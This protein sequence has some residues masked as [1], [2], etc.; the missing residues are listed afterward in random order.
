MGGSSG[1]GAKTPHVA[2]ISLESAQRLKIVDLICEG[3]KDLTHPISEKDVLLNGTPLQNA[4]D[5]YNFEGVEL[6]FLP[7]TADQDYLPGFESS[8][9]VVSVG[10]EIKHS[11]SVTRQ[12]IDPNISR[13]RITIGFNALEEIREN[14]DTEATS[15][16]IEVQLHNV[17]RNLK[18]SQRV[19][20]SGRT[21]STYHRDIEFS[22]LPPTPFNMTVIRHTEDS[23]SSS[24]RNKSFLT[25]YVESIDAK[26]NYPHSVVVGI[27]ID[28]NLFG[29]NV[30]T[31]TYRSHWTVVEVPSNYNPETREYNGIWNGTFKRAWT[32]NP[33]WIY[34]DLVLND[35]YGLARYRTDI[36]VD[37][38]ALYSIAQYCDELVDDGNGGQEPRFTCNCYITSPRDAYDV[39]SDLAS[40][41][42]GIAFYDGLQYVA[43]QDR[44][45][46]PVAVYGNS[47]VVDGRF[48]YSGVSYKDITTACIVKFADKANSFI[49]DS[50]Q[51]QDDNAIARFG[52][53]VKQ[54]TA[55]GC[56]SRGQAQRVA[57]WMVETAIRERESVSFEV[58]REGIKHLPYDIIRIADNDY[59]GAQLSARVLAVDGEV[60]ALD[61]QADAKTRSIK[62]L[63]ARA[64]EQAI[65]VVSVDGDKLTLER[66]PDGIKTTGVVMMTLSDVA[67]RLFRAISITENNDKGT[68][69]ISAIT[70]D[71]NKAAIVDGGATQI[72]DASTTRYTMP[73]VYNSAVSTNGQ[74]LAIT[75]SATATKDARYLIK[76]YRDGELY[77]SMTSDS[78]Q[79]SIAGLPNGQYR[80][81]IV[82]ID[83]QGR[84]S[85]PQEQT[86]TISYDITNLTATG[87]V[88]AIRLDWQVPVLLLGHGAT[89]IWHSKQNDIATAQRIAD[90]SYPSN[91]FIY[92][93]A[94]L[95]EVHYFWVR[96]RD[97]KG[98]TGAWQAAQGQ[99]SDD[100]GAIVDYLHGQIT[101][102]ALSAE[103]IASLTQ[104]ID[105]AK[106]GA[107]E[108]TRQAIEQARQTLEQAINNA[109]NDSNAKIAQSESRLRT[110]I[111]NNS[112]EI[113]NAKQSISTNTQS[114]NQVRES[115]N[116]SNQQANAA[117]ESV[118]QTAANNSQAISTL[119]NTLSAKMRNN[120]SKISQL[121]TAV[122][123]N[124]GNIASVSTTLSAVMQ[125][126]DNLVRNPSMREDTA[127]WSA[128]MKRTV[129]QNK[130][131]GLLTYRDQVYQPWIAC[132]PGDKYYLAAEIKNK[133]SNAWARI[134]LFGV[135]ET[136]GNQWLIAAASNSSE[137]TRIEGEIEI[138]E[139]IEQVQFWASIDKPESSAGSYYIRNIEMRK[140]NQNR[141][142]HAEINTIRQITTNNTSAI[143]QSED[144]LNSRINDNNAQI[145]T[146]KQTTATTN[147]SLAN[148]ST[149]LTA[150][151][152][153]DPNNLVLNPD[154]EGLQYWAPNWLSSRTVDGRSVGVISNRDAL[155][156]TTI[157]VKAGDIFY[158][159]AEFKNIDARGNQGIGLRV[160]KHDGSVQWMI[161]NYARIIQ[162]W[163]TVNGYLT[164]PE[165][166]VSAQVWL[167]IEADWNSTGSSYVRHVYVTRA[168][169]IRE[170]NLLQMPTEHGL[171]KGNNG[172]SINTEGDTY[173]LNK[174][175]TQ[176]WAG[177]Y[178]HLVVGK[179]MLKPHTNYLL[180][181]DIEPNSTFKMDVFVRPFNVPNVSDAYHADF[182][183]DGKKRISLSFNSGDL[184]NA[185]GCS[186]DVEIPNGHRGLVR[187]R[188]FILIAG[189]SAD[190]A[191]VAKSAY[192]IKTEA[193]AGGRKAIAGIALGAQV[194]NKTAESSVI[195]MAD[196]FGI[197]KNAGD[198]N[199]RPIFTIADNKA[200]LNGDLIASGVILGKHIRA[201]QA[202]AAPNINGGK[203][204]G[205]TINNGNG[206]FSVDANGNMTAKSGRFG[207]LVSGGSININNRFIV[208]AQGN[209]TANAGVFNG[210]VYADNIQGSFAQY[211]PNIDK[212]S[213]YEFRIHVG[214]RRQ[215]L[216]WFFG[217]RLH[218][219]DIKTKRF[220]ITLSADNQ[221]ISKQEIGRGIG[222]TG[223][224]FSYSGR[225]LVP[226][227]DYIYLRLDRGNYKYSLD[228]FDGL[229]AIKV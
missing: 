77:K 136:Q 85:E 60:I 1:G 21:N 67:P 37:K 122:S 63:D 116:S 218:A 23:K 115:L 22:D 169:E 123:N 129:V 228:Y 108:E 112:A 186:I 223:G 105:G 140:A 145:N 187:M 12:I 125:D 144:R 106:S 178:Q 76:I 64:Q 220:Y 224:I 73:Q 179:N 147:A 93:G 200:A 87:E 36:K 110:Q 225:V 26:L 173:V 99:A 164:M 142:I 18:K 199:V 39:L 156:G 5:S 72:D 204:T 196:K 174:P 114:I 79:V 113:S 139:G 31:R 168:D 68:Y 2:P 94:E 208:D 146:L 201:G 158:L 167:Q 182:I 96:L 83:A 216:L 111:D 151:A 20:I 80:A 150:H 19:T 44:Q 57:K 118:R 7:G 203:V 58:G 95:G 16:D 97:D 6:Y 214:K 25:S 202:I 197:V 137:W 184:T 154:F 56:T 226:S 161:V 89:E 134:G 221:E 29:G 41:F 84:Q 55:F 193:I 188:N 143:A 46:D 198:S 61:R 47:N 78:P 132:N 206:T 104:Q 131:M 209:M 62:Y 98:N 9:T 49:T 82:A 3:V 75:W 207:G 59:A 103:L 91:S 133:D 181:F 189:E 101:Q 157:P 195:V 210:I 213:D 190:A 222:N 153:Q 88:F 66:A 191:M 194:D 35:R 124:T 10:T 33:A 32:D 109:K 81:E 70:H 52:Y 171:Y 51:Y 92:Q 152:Q 100:A 15:V 165:D 90:V 170:R 86:W 217:L 13:L 17:A 30:P 45:R 14:G 155:Y 141:Q 50:V 211:F 148:L 130:A 212:V 42:R 159:S 229:L 120:E 127:S 102:D 172:G 128:G 53:N 24:M 121:N 8:D 185:T 38:W 11:Q 163:E 126:P 34:R 227:A 219:W 65:N 192:T 43:I 135:S 180:S 48:E 117:I 40:C 215:T 28:S 176:D 162:N 54:L 74:A 205:T 183:A 138:P 166:A 177:L 160:V 107:V 4:D 69:T 27:K 149:T 71:P 119:D 175:D